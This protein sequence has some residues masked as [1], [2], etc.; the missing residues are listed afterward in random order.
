MKTCPICNYKEFDVTVLKADQFKLTL[1]KCKSCCSLFSEEH[2][3]VEI[4]SG[5]FDKSYLGV[6]IHPVDGDDCGRL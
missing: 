1:Y 2:G 4:V 5:E 6:N 3:K